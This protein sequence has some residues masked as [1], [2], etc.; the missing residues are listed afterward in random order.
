MRII[1]RCAFAPL[2]LLICVNL[3]P[4]V[5]H[6]EGD[7]VTTQNSDTLVVHQGFYGPGT[8]ATVLSVF[9]PEPTEGAPEPLG[10]F[11]I[12]AV[13]FD[14]ADVDESGQPN[15]LISDYVDL[16]QIRI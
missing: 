13:S 12:P 3:V 1:S 15:G 9:L 6:A 10:V 7:K 11:I 2:A 8:G 4:Q 16:P 5:A 14:L